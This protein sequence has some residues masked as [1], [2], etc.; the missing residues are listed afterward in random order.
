MTVYDHL[1]VFRIRDHLIHIS[2]WEHSM[3]PSL[4]S[5]ALTSGHSNHWIRTV[6]FQ[7]RDIWWVRCIRSCSIT[8]G[9]HHSIHMHIHI[10]SSHK[11]DAHIAERTQT[12]KALC[13]LPIPVLV[14]TGG[15]GILR[16]L[17]GNLVFSMILRSHLHK[18]L[19]SE[20]QG[21]R[22][23]VL[24]KW[25]LTT[26]KCRQAPLPGCMRLR[27]QWWPHPKIKRC[28]FKSFLSSKCISF[29]CTSGITVRLLAS[30]LV[31]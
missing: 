24:V 19:I 4:W 9:L 21:R 23:K 29:I 28:H 12:D 6:G 11:F 17:K 22:G 3:W 10:A 31:R 7:T 14:Q 25:A 20:R 1:N 26:H 5:L 8:G 15:W 30:P 2:G 18:Q 13:I 27:R 16:K